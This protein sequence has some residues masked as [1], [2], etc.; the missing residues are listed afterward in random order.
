MKISVICV[1]LHIKTYNNVPL[2]HESLKVFLSHAPRVPYELII[3]DNGS[4]VD[5]GTGFRKAFPAAR[6]VELPRNMGF[7]KAVNAGAAYA[8]GEYIMLHNPDIA[9]TEGMLDTLIA[10]MDTH[11]DVAMVGPRL[12]NEDGTIQDTYRRFMR[13]MDFLIK[14]MRFLHRYPYFQSRMKEYLMWD[15]DQ[16][17]IQEVDWMQA[18]CVVI[19]R[20]MLEQIGGM[21]ELF[22]LFM[23]DM[24][25]GRTFKEH[26][27]KVIYYPHVYAFH[28]SKRLSGN[29]F[30]KSLVKWTAW[31]HLWEVTKYMWRW[32]GDIVRPASQKSQEEAKNLA[33]ASVA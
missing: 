7:Q 18:S 12:M 6:V 32:R 20:S 33:P 5:E 28:G 30:W 19:R 4:I 23:G 3:V 21:N 16:N 27:L 11:Q 22:F 15:V 24:D 26:G 17:K 9:V 10:Y 31:L 13:P 29:G 25:L 1:A 8:T 14:R 2:Y